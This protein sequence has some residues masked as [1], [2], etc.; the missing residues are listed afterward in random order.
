MLISFACSKDLQN[1]TPDRM[2]EAKAKRDLTNHSNSQLLSQHPGKAFEPA[3][4]QDSKASGNGLL[5][6]R[7]CISIF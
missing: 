6:K 1:G 4:T 3:L 7:D 2:V 5:Y